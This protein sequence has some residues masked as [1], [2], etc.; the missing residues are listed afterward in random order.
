MRHADISPSLW[1]NKVSDTL[2]LRCHICCMWSYQEGGG[3]GKAQCSKGR[4]APSDSGSGWNSA[5]APRDMWARSL[6]PHGE[7]FHIIID[8]PIPDC[9][10]DSASREIGKADSQQ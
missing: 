3:A 2:W 4:A 1:A 5:A 9:N 8:F 10:L 7:G 6:E